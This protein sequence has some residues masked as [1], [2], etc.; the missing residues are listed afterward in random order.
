MYCQLITACPYEARE[1]VHNS[2]SVRLLNFQP[3]LCNLIFGDIISS[4]LLYLQVP[5]YIVPLGKKK[6]AQ[7][8]L[9]H[10]IFEHYSEGYV[11]NSVENVG[12]IV[13]PW[14]EHGCFHLPRI[15][16]FDQVLRKGSMKQSHIGE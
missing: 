15:S 4:L 16:N 2:E 6:A 1:Q 5:I 11:F 14:D 8:F 9:S 3:A 10:Y 12:S 13:S 7:R